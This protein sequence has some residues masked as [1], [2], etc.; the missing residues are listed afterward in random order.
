[1][2][3]YLT[4]TDSQGNTFT[5]DGSS[6]YVVAN[7]SFGTLQQLENGAVAG[8][9]SFQPL[10]FQLGSNQL[11]L[12]LD[13]DLA[14]GAT[15]S[16]I[17]LYGYD[18][19][20]TT[21]GMVEVVHD[22]FKAASVQSDAVSPG[23]G[24]H[25]FSISYRGL[26]ESISPILAD[27]TQAPA[28]TAGWNAV[29]NTADN[30][31][32]TD[33]SGAPANVPTGDP[34]AAVPLSTPTIDYYVR[35][36]EANGDVLGGGWIELQGA[37]F[38]LDESLS[39][40]SSGAGSGKVSLQS[41]NLN[42]FAGQLGS[43]LL[44]MEAEGAHLAQIDVA[45]YSVTGT[46]TNPLVA[47]YRFKTAFVTGGT[48]AFGDLQTP[49]Y[50]FSYAAEQ[51]AYYA[52]GATTPTTVESSNGNATFADNSLPTTEAGLQGDKAS[53]SGGVGKDSYMTFTDANGNT[54]SP[55]GNVLYAVAPPS[56]SLM[57][58]ATGSGTGGAGAGKLAFPPLT[59][60]L[61]QDALSE[62]LDQDMASG[63]SLSQ[64]NLFG[65]RPDPGQPNSEAQVEQDVFKDV[66]ITSDTVDATT[67]T[68]TFTATYGGLVES[69][70]PINTD[71]SLGTPTIGG[72][73]AVTNTPDNSL[74]S[75][76]AGVGGSSVTLPTIDPS[77]GSVAP[78]STGTDTFF[79]R[80]LNSSDAAI[81]GGWIEVTDATLGFDLSGAKVGFAPL[82]LTFDPGTLE[83]TL[84]Q[85]EAAGTP[86]AQI[87][88]AEYTSGVSGG[89]LIDDYRFNSA[90]LTGSAR[91][92]Q[93]GSEPTFTYTFQY[94]D[95]QLAYF[96]NGPTSA[97]IVEGWNSETNSA[98]A[99]YSVGSVPTTRQAVEGQLA[100]TGTGEGESTTYYASFTT[101]DGNT[102]SADGS[103]LYQISGFN[104]GA[105]NNGAFSFQPLTF[106]L[107]SN[108]LTALL[109][110][111][112]ATGAPL[113]EVNVY[114]FKTT[115]GGTQV[116]VLQDAFKLAAVQSDTVDAALGTHAFNLEYGGLVE[117]SAPLNPN[118]SQGTPVTAGWN[119]IAGV[120]DNSLTSTIDGVGGSNIMLPTVDPATA[121][122]AP[123]TSPTDT[124]YVRFL[125]SANNE[126]GGGWRA[127]NDATLGLNQAVT[128][129]LPGAQVGAETFSPL[130]LTFEPGNLEPTLLAL[131][132]AGTS[133]AQ[134]DVA[135]YC[136]RKRGRLDARRR[137]P[138]Q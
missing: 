130:N 117:S 4:F 127:L 28:V 132:G 53:L 116:Q 104:Q 3:Y 97:P 73:N 94:S 37:G 54:L 74:T 26:V 83:S 115:Q 76:V 128:L 134:I 30:N 95:E 40:G 18:D 110:Q 64:I 2:Q 60:T 123:A 109:D 57:S 56:T 75:T 14:S 1:M 43:T 111:D 81:G 114:G 65:Y 113:A 67:G 137:L 63:A 33:I 72:W 58:A 9:M 108:E 17:N 8:S 112:M 82:K 22:V 106:T 105:E 131:E 120:A 92:T 93:T 21:G 103:S 68:H 32:T 126:I 16:Q 48:P 96:N 121:I 125:D 5:A 36:T 50:T 19:D 47:D 15:L 11:A 66:E 91:A 6:F 107:G 7:V 42:F 99:T 46:G 13:Q 136:A 77:Q 98:D 90:T 55:D 129:G 39:S 24:T 89:S 25:N 10:T 85:A 31:L 34:S 70:T 87:D 23:Q 119:A 27:G 101:A 29:T 78:R 71:G 133:I 135:A 84:L 45:A 12:Q 61:G 79:V 118:G 138:L 41:L 44:Q 69:A 100:Q 35:F 102:F 52:G 88:V 62:Q 59:F 38:T 80:F 20:A 124:L 86:F 49:T 122:A 51:I